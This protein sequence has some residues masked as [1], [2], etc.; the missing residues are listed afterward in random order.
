MGTAW[1][2]VLE[3]AGYPTTAIVLDFETYF[4]ASYSLKKMSTIEYV[5]D[6]R[7]EILGLGAKFLEICKSDLLTPQTI[8][9]LIAVIAWDEVTVI[10]QNLKFD[11]LI[12]AR[13]FGITPKY[14]VDTRDLDRI[15]DARDKHNLEYMAKKWGSLKPKGDT[16]RFKGLH[17]VDMDEAKRQELADYT[18]TDVE[19]EADIFQKLMPLIP[20]PE[21]ELPLATQTLHMYL[22][23]N[24]VV[25]FKLGN[26]LIEEMQQEMLKA[27]DGLEWILDYAN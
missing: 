19:I 21:I 17:W 23:P 11:C 1:K 18:K 15:W 10:G 5:C 22:Q 14:T 9:D 7:F 26:K 6:P 13:K 27:I 16:Q 2:K 12:L 24:I 20:N 8:K 3:R 25:D 4:D